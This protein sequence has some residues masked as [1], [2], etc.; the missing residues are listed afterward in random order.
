MSDAVDEFKSLVGG[1]DTSHDHAKKDKLEETKRVE[2]ERHEA[3]KE[4]LAHEKHMQKEK[5]KEELHEAKM[6]R[7]MHGHG[8]RR[9]KELKELHEKEVRKQHDRHE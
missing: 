1:R 6:K 5:E 8:K 4:I 2:R 3:H 9:E 7:M